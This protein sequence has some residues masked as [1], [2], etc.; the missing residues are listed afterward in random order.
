M[1][2]EKLGDHVTKLYINIGRTF[3]AFCVAIDGNK[4]AKKS[5]CQRNV[6]QLLVVVINIMY[7]VLLDYHKN[8]RRRKYLRHIIILPLD[9]KSKLQSCHVK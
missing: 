1:V 6:G 5:K 4:V 3:L 7:L 8:Q 9:L 2:T